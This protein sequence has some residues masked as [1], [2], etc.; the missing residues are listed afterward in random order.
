M[1]APGADDAEQWEQTLD[2]EAAAF[3]DAAGDGGFTPDQ[4]PEGV[5]AATPQPQG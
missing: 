2:E 3:A 5:G 4:S 1:I